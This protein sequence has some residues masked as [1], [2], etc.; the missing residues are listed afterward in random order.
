MQPLETNHENVKPVMKVK[1]SGLSPYSP[2]LS[3]PSS[4]ESSMELSN[5]RKDS[6]EDVDALLSA[7]SSSPDHVPNQTPQWS[8]ISASPRGEDPPQ[9]PDFPPQTPE[10]NGTN[11]APMKSPPMHNNMGHPPGYDPNRI[12]A[13]IFSS[14]PNNGMEWSTAS[15]ES[16]FSIHMGNNSFSRDQLNMMYRSGELIK[17]EEWSNSPYNAPE[18][19]SNEKK[20]LPPSL[21]P[22]AEMATD[23]EVKSETELESPPLQGKIVEAPKVVPLENHE[24]NIKEKKKPNVDEVASA[25]NK[26]DEIPHSA[27]FPNKSD[28]KVVPQFE[29]TSSPRLSNESGN[30]SSSFAFP[31]LL[32]DAGKTGSL[33]A[34]S[35][36]MGRPQPQPKPQPD[37]QPEIQ[38]QSPPYSKPESE[39]PESQPKLEATTWF[40]CYSCWPQCC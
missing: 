13:S 30:S 23:K 28:G 5:R 36:K 32:N 3:S 25:I 27:S 24:N 14:K 26:S 11:P 20:N 18:V 4:S 31:V 34:P 29:T 22:V 35:A 16:L 38:P 10:W 8:M 40:S 1:T 39:Q 7:S 12:P 17:P 2:S 33:K 9:F 6:L 21:P 19:K 37:S 15:N